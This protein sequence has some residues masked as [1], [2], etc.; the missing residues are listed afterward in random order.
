MTLSV[1]STGMPPMAP[2][3]PSS[4]ARKRN[5]SPASVPRAVTTES[6]HVV[7]VTESCTMPPGAGV[8]GVTDSRGACACPTV[9]T[10]PSATMP[11]MSL[12]DMQ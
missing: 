8:A 11:A 2:S 10:A 3:R 5:G 4:P 9:A 6:A 12:S 7:S 1:A